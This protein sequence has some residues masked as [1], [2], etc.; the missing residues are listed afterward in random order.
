MSWWRRAGG[1]L[2]KWEGLHSVTDGSLVIRVWSV[3]LLTDVRVK[4]RTLHQI[5]THTGRGANQ[6]GICRDGNTHTVCTGG[7]RE[8]S[9]A[10]AI[11][12]KKKFLFWSCKANTH[13]KVT[14]N[15]VSMTFDPSQ[16]GRDAA[17][18]LACTWMS[19]TRPIGRTL[20]TEYL[21]S[22]RRTRVGEDFPFVSSIFGGHKS[23][24]K[25][26]RCKCLSERE[27]VLGAAARK[28]INASVS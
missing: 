3:A 13:A 10:N 28:W 5:H 1:S 23:S 19:A 20:L 4:E 16:R 12:S 15:F 27:V 6:V 11:C 8:F 14:L 22:A 21:H 2:P 25:R 24:C 7:R 9:S 18:N 17:W 26:I